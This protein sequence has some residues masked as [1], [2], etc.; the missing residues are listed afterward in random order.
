[1]RLSIVNLNNQL[2]WANMS[3]EFKYNAGK[4]F[5]YQGYGPSA[6]QGLENAREYHIRN[7]HLQ[8]DFDQKG[9][10]KWSLKRKQEEMPVAALTAL[11]DAQGNKIEGMVSGL[12]DIT[13]DEEIIGGAIIVSQGHYLDFSLR[14]KIR[15]FFI[16]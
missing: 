16:L 14:K 7:L 6:V 2:N 10:V 4:I 3:S 9:E 15:E 5:S 12:L 1:M 8:A 11:K 13:K